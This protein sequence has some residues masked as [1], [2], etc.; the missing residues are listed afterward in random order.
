MAALG[1]SPDDSEDADEANSR[2][3]IL[4]I[5]VTFTIN[6]DKFRAVKLPISTNSPTP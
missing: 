3:P 6:S 1:A 2:G 4:G 5:V